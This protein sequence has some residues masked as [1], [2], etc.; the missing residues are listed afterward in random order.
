MAKLGGEI[1]KCQDLFFFLMAFS[2]LKHWVGLW[3]LKN[4]H[5]NTIEINLFTGLLL[6]CTMC[7]E[8]LVWMGEKKPTN[9]RINVEELNFRFLLFDYKNEC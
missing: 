2:Y 6:N 7:D 8:N 5:L 1:S 4:R 9:L 3:F